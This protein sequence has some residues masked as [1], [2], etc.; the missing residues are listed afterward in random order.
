MFRVDHHP[1]P[2]PE[3]P[4]ALERLKV[5]GPA[6]YE[7]AIIADRLRTLKPMSQGIRPDEIVELPEPIDDLAVTLLE[8][9]CPHQRV[10]FPLLAEDTV[11][12]GILEF[13]EAVT[14]PGRIADDEVGNVIAEE[15]ELESDPVDA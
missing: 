3:Q 8:P 2:P 11:R 10:F 6:D 7:Q 1:T 14:M 5:T 4:V 15:V 9:R 12:S 13:D